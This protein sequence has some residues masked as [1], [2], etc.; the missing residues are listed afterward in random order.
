LI[1]P[2]TGS[3]FGVN[4]GLALDYFLS[5]LGPSLGSMR[6]SL[7]SVLA[8]THSAHQ[9]SHLTPLREEI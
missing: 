6:W 2:N 5:S 9:F 8:I 3:N 4:G 7:A 1:L